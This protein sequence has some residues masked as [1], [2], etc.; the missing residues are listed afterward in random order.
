MGIKN[1]RN[2]H[3]LRTLP[4]LHIIEVLKMFWDLICLEN[5]LNSFIIIR[6]V[7]SMPAKR[8]IKKYYKLSNSMKNVRNPHILHTFPNLHFLEV[9]KIVLD[10]YGLYIA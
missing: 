4:N 8:K 5:C 3:I 1:A 7:E 9:L 6:G 2:P 10:S